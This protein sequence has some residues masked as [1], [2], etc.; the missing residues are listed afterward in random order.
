MTPSLMTDN[1]QQNENINKSPYLWQEQ[2]YLFFRFQKNFTLKKQ[3]KKESKFLPTNISAL[4]LLQACCVLLFFPVTL[5]TPF[6]CSHSSCHILFFQ[7]FSILLL[8]SSNTFNIPEIVLF[9]VLLIFLSGIEIMNFELS[10]TFH[11]FW[12]GFLSET[13]R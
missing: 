3:T 5:A 11:H 12:T 7:Q 4:L 9:H 10:F 8:I 1:H 13:R 6:T 2:Y